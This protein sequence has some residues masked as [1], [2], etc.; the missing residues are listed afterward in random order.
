V[1]SPTS[2]NDGIPS[3]CLILVSDAQAVSTS[4]EHWSCIQSRRK[5]WTC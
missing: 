2:K 1:W 5:L 3:A 4:F